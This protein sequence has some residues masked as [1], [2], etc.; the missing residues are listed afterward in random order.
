MAGGIAIETMLATAQKTLVTKLCGNPFALYVGALVML[1]A[2]LAALPP[3]TATPAAALP[4]SD[5]ENRFS[6]TVVSAYEADGRLL[7]RLHS[8]RLHHVA[9]RSS[10]TPGA[11]LEE[12]RL[13]YRAHSGAA[14][15][16]TAAAGRIA[17]DGAIHPQGA[18]TL[19]RARHAQRAAA[20]LQTRNV[21]VA[22][23]DKRA[24]TREKAV[25]RRGRL[26]S[27]GDGM[28]ADLRT[29]EIRLLSNVRVTHSP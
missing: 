3:V 2:A 4:A 25:L 29:G 22:T 19:Q 7:Y 10:G 21:V 12:P 20:T 18:V 5:V 16:L 28:S 6:E 24:H 9:E 27:R 13:T 11:H 1:G 15:E 17:A 14:V 26:V 8:P 23:R